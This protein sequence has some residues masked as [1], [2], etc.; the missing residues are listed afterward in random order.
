MMIMFLFPKKTY[1]KVEDEVSVEDI[2]KNTEVI[3]E[4]LIVKDAELID[5]EHIDAEHIDAEDKKINI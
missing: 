3:N 5:A 4:E 2:A 1:N